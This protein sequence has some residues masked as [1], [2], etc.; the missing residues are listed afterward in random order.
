MLQL[1]LEMEKNRQYTSILSL[2]RDAEN[3]QRRLCSIYEKC[4]DELNKIL[5]NIVVMR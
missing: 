1:T 3:E 2:R 5:D 4:I